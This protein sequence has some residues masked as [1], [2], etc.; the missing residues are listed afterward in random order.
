MFQFDGSHERT[1]RSQPTVAPRWFAYLWAFPTTCVG[2]A[3]LPLSW[4]GGRVVVVDGVMECC[5]PGLKRV[6][7]RLGPHGGVAAIALGHVVLAQD[8]RS[9][10]WTRAHERVHVRQCEYWGP[11]FVPAYLLASLVALASGGRP[12]LDNYFERQARSESGT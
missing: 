5:G 2:L 6:L 1:S 9:L 7:A 11:L 3:A 12:Y 4:F 10:D 8:E